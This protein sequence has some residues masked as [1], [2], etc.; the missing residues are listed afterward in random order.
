MKLVNRTFVCGDLHGSNDI[1]KLS[2]LIFKEQEDLT[3]DDVVIQLGDFGLIWYPFDSDKNEESAYFLNWLVTR[4]FTTFVIPGN[5]ENYDIIEKLDTC[6]MFGAEVFYYDSI[7]SFGEGRI[8][9]AKRGEIYTINDKTFW[10]FGG[11]LSVD[12]QHRVLGQSYWPR[13]LPSYFEYENGMKNLDM[14]NWEVDYV[15]SHTCPAN[16]IPNIL[17]SQS[18]VFSKVNDPV[19]EYFF[20]IYKKLKFKEWH[21]GH[22]HKDMK[23]DFSSTNNG[24]FYV[25]YNNPPHELL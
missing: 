9:F 20:E 22:F 3:K 7:E 25:H 11:A 5:H 10:A 14:V 12:K 24:I 2:E 1:V 4:P 6:M 18:K 19:S 13:E 21:F 15:V 17:D 8:Y 23:L 16:I